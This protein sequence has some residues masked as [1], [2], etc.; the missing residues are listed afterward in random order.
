[1]FSSFGAKPGR[2]AFGNASAV[3]LRLFLQINGHFLPCGYQGKFAHKPMNAVKTE[4][5]EIKCSSYRQDHSRDEPPMGRWSA[6]LW[7]VP[8][9]RNV[10]VSK[11]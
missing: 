11:V 7:T 8:C 1:M 6:L 9:G 5:V 10:M 3:S 2:T 4:K